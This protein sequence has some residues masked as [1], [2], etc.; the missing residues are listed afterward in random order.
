MTRS[1][2]ALALVPVAA[3]LAL[4]GSLVV[5]AA[6]S[7]SSSATAPRPTPA[8]RAA[9]ITTAGGAYAG[10][11]VSG[12]PGREVARTTLA[13]QPQGI[14]VSNYQ[15]A[16]DW[17]SYAASGISFAYVKATEGTGYTNPSFAQQYDG[18]YGAGMT[19][20]AY[21]FAL[22]DRSSGAAQATYFVQHGGGW[23]A[24]GRTLPGALDIEYNP[25][26]ATC[27][28]L[29]AAAMVAWVADFSDTYRSL[30]GRDPVIYTTANWWDTCTASNTSRGAVN[31]L[32]VAR[33]ASSVGTLP[34]GWGYH[35][36]WQHSSDP[37]DQDLFNGTADRLAA[38]A[39]G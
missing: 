32:W 30:T 9:G 34:A 12:S 28:G 11:E 6:A 24:D 27:F 29:S 2:R 17:G 15:G 8:A 35:T 25:Y 20:G 1:R 23:S 14:D 10:W 38:L 36:I 7:A 19:R 37:V 16:V 13:G 4:A 33:Y 31:P 5:P 22:P 18:S 39:L 26:G 21:H 3:S